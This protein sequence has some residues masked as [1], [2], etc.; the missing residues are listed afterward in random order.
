MRRQ[1]LSVG[2][3][4]SV[5]D[6]ARNHPK[7]RGRLMLASRPIW[8]PLR[9]MTSTFLRA[10][11]YSSEIPLQESGKKKILVVSAIQE[12]GL[13]RISK[14]IFSGLSGQF[15]VYFVRL[16]D[17]EIET[18]FQGSKIFSATG[19]FLLDDS[20][21]NDNFDQAF[22][23]LVDLVNPDI[24][25]LEHLNKI[26]HP[27][28][29]QLEASRI[30]I[31]HT[32]HDY[33]DLCP[34]HNLLDEKLVFCGGICT[35]GSGWC[36]MSL[37]APGDIKMIKNDFVHEWR[38]LNI[39]LLKNV[40]VIFSP[41]KYSAELF[42]ETYPTLRDRVLVIPHGVYQEPQSQK[43]AI[44]RTLENILYLGN[45][46]PAKGSNKL[47]A[48]AIAGAKKKITFHHLGRAPLQFRKWA[49]LLGPYDERDFAKIL[50]EV[51]P[52]CVIVASIWPETFGLV[53]DEAAS[54]GVPIISLA[55][56]DISERVLQEKI[57]L[58]LDP[59]SSPDAILADIEKFLLDT[60]SVREV[61]KGLGLFRDGLGGRH[62][63]MMNSYRVVFE[64]A[65][66]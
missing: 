6:F 59:S 5:M 30:F 52:D 9:R 17:F 31:S 1:K 65:S 45:Y 54:M 60:T 58:V 40:N 64:N 12:G 36:D 32:I 57:G 53:V 47:K 15:D 29:Q 46:L 55:L 11:T 66:I 8:N 3:R 35:K 37:I 33:F 61:T 23:N 42:L 41:S 49:K 2:I 51:N 62:S 56:G 20:Q 43:I 24:I 39:S 25:H 44:R 63:A 27:A 22:L 16:T 13:A 28:I 21:R 14:E 38:K 19:N 18:R 26:S 48:L 10:G 34:S 4:E 50:S 7:L